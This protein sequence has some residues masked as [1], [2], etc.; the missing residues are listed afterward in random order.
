MTAIND[1]AVLLMASCHWVNINQV[2]TYARNNM[3]VIFI[4]VIITFSDDIMVLY[5]QGNAI[6]QRWSR[7]PKNATSVVFLVIFILFTT[8]CNKWGSTKHPRASSTLT[9]L[10]HQRSQVD[11]ISWFTKAVMTSDLTALAHQKQTNVWRPAYFRSCWL[12]C[13]RYL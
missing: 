4:H 13:S 2:Y 11:I 8:G 1:T 9:L 3:L 6:R 10:N 5:L 7:P 12:G